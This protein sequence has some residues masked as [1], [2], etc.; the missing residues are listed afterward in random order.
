MELLDVTSSPNQILGHNFACILRYWGQYTTSQVRSANAYKLAS[1]CALLDVHDE[2]LLA[3]LQLCAFPIEFSLRFGER[4]L[5]L[6]QTLRWSNSTAEQGFLGEGLDDDI[7]GTEG[8][9]NDIHG[10]KR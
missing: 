3:L 2:F 4:A 10:G 1:L 5:V 7:E 6:A 8:T 9:Y